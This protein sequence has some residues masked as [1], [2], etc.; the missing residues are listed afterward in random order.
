MV[1]GPRGVAAAARRAVW[2]L[3]AVGCH[4]AAR[5]PTGSPA[6][7]VVAAVP[8]A[9]AATGIVRAS[10]A[11]DGDRACAIEATGKVACWGS[12]PHGGATP[13]E[14][15]ALDDVTGLAAGPSA[16]CAWTTHGAV[17]CW[18]D[19]LR[20]R[21][22][23][24]FD[25]VVQVS[26]GIDSA[27]GLHASGRVTCWDD[28]SNAGREVAGV[29]DAVE[30]AGAAGFGAEAL[31]ARTKAGAVT[32][33]N[34]VSPFEPLPELAGATSLA[35]AGGRFAALV[36]GHRLARWV[37]WTGA[38]M[39]MILDGVDADRV[40]VG[41]HLNGAAALCVLGAHARCWTWSGEPTVAL[42][43]APPLPA[44][45]R[46]LAFDT[47]ATCGRIGDRVACW[48]RRGRLGDGEPEYPRDLVPVAGLADAR[49][50]EAAGRTLCALRATGKVACWGERLRGADDDRGVVAIDRTPVELPG[51]TDAVEIAM[52]SADRGDGELGVA[53]LVCARRPRGATCWTTV[54]GHLQAADA[55]ALASAVK[56][57]AGPTV[58]GVTA[59]RA[60][61]CVPL[62]LTGG[63]VPG[64]S[65]DDYERYVYQGSSEDT[66]RRIADELARRL[67]RALASNQR[68]DGFHGANVSD[69][70]G[71]TSAAF[72]PPLDKLTAVP[73]LRRIA[74]AVDWDQARV[75]GALCARRG[76][77]TVG[78]WGERDYLGVDQRSTRADPVEVAGVVMGPPR[79]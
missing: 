73:E 7:V 29:V 53:V 47:E 30:I 62:P 16:T 14:V 72:R 59:G 56:L 35:G 21:F 11:V 23:P 6:P 52:A 60:V 1:H 76:D 20:T 74:W 48:G 41:G 68:L 9:A 70:I 39:A 75:R 27:C 22:A 38:L 37:G 51:V 45:L 19:D 65:P 15:P 24:P 61:R 54:H 13:V 66:G 18:G 5:P 4:P 44:G 50:L 3:V 71:A 17:A 49:Q 26:V 77:G 58:C 46:D 34:R 67:H 33:G 2:I 32:C 36:P 40:L 55:P 63:F 12:G 79:R 78:C 31:C 43:D 57:Y 8:V 10:L 25:D 69:P 28:G 64:F 42:A